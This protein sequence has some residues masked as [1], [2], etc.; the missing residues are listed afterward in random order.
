ML[1]LISEPFGLQ[2]VRSQACLAN[3]RRAAAKLLDWSELRLADEEERVGVETV[4]LEVT[5][6]WR[7]ETTVN[8]RWTLLVFVIPWFEFELIKPGA[9]SG[10]DGVEGSL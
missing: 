6:W 1:A 8:E 2:S 3:L 5:F 9:K 4:E 10:I 7:G